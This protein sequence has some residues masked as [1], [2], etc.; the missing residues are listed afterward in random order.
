M[1]EGNPKQG[2]V[3]G[4]LNRLKS[5]VEEV[6]ASLRSQ[7]EILKP[8]GVTLPP[9]VLSSLK[10]I[11]GNLDKVEE[12]L[13][14]DQTEL[15]QLRVL[16]ETAAMINSTL[17]LDKVLNDS[18]DVVTNLTGA[19]R[20]YIILKNE[21]TGELEF[22]VQRDM[23]LVPR[24]DVSTEG[25]QISRTILNECIDDGIPLLVDNA[26]KDE[27]LQSKLS[28]ANFVLRSVLCV[29][30]QFQ[31]LTIG[32][33]YVDNRLRAGVFTERE[34][35]LLVAFANT[36]AVAITNARLF[37]SIQATLS[38]ITEVKDL[39]DN[40]F[41]SIG[42]GVITTNVADQVDTFNPAAARILERSTEDSIGLHLG[43]VLPVIAVNLEEHLEVVREQGEVQVFDT[44]ME[45]AQRGLI[46]VNMKFAPLKD[47]GQNTQG[48]AM[49]LEDL[50]EQKQ[51]EQEMGVM[52]RYLPPE[53]VDKID[54][55]S[56]IG[57]GAGERR[58]VSCLYIDVRSIHTMP[59][60]MRPTEIMDLVNVYL[61]VATGCIH[62][63][64]GVID[65]Y[66]GNEI[67]AMFNTQLN[68]M[69]DHSTRAV[70][71][72]LMARDAFLE[73]YQEQGINPDPHYYRVGI[74][75][76]A[77]T[78]GNVGSK[79]R[80]D[81][82]AIGDTINLSKRLEENATGGQIIVSDD[83]RQRMEADAKG[84]ELPV[85]FEK[86]GTVQVKGREQETS[87][88]EVFRQS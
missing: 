41:A 63:L 16:A 33:V 45:V 12:S 62:S 37:T 65:K 5:L 48:V 61:A 13:L 26:Y 36:A 85:R 76:G 81:F 82:T 47:S 68:P 18:M 50:T 30:L 27:R 17:D 70:E 75:T 10:S 7:N 29:P 79:T 19:E 49:V 14:D 31:D 6:T 72:A 74:H 71:V 42:S 39:M 78:L 3:I 46:A 9:L 40:V 38:E 77:A 73:F 66:M 43:S 34:K 4:E 51:R 8:R 2:S 20:G 69:E 28:I 21:D 11:K 60:G 22:R 64:G 1:V 15:G 59:E 84:E 56:Q 53:M 58:D 44:E 55:I 35:N 57:L 25:P 88:Y 80:R 52:K 83:I 67:M 32:A 24:M 86:R 87:I 23:E 54:S